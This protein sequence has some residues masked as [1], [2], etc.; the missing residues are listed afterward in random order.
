[1]GVVTSRYIESRLFYLVPFHGTCSVDRVSPAAEKVPLNLV[2]IDLLLDRRWLCR[3]F[4]TSLTRTHEASSIFGLSVGRRLGLPL[5]SW[6]LGLGRLCGWG[7]DLFKVDWG[8][9][10]ESS[11]A[12][13]SVVIGFDP[14]GDCLAELGPG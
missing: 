3:L 2:C 7:V 1:V 9:S 13:F 11:L 8:L 14:G 12:A 10:T 5:F 6:R 4:G